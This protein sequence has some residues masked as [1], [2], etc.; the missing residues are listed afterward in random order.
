[1]WIMIVIYNVLLYTV[2]FYEL[3]SQIFVIVS[4]KI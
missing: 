3:L 4:F 1:M 2:P